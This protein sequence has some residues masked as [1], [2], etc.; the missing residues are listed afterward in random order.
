D[1][2]NG[3][4]LWQSDGTDIGT[5]MVQDIYPGSAGSNPSS[6]TA[7]NNKLYFAATDP[8]HGRELWDPPA[9]ETG[10]APR[11]VTVLNALDKGDGSLRDAIGHA[12]DGDTIV[13]DQSLS[14]QTITLTSGAL[15]IKN[16]LDIEGPGANRLA[17]SGN[18]SSRIFD[19]SAGLTVTIA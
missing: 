8:V 17:V 14:G 10:T 12:R 11:T 9:V 6:L 5:V 2:V 15:V 4:E 1:S 13:F 19:I 7:M 3:R 18:D 16:S